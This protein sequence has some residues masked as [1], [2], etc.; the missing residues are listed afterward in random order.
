MLSKT[1]MGIA[2]LSKATNHREHD[3][4]VAIAELLIVHMEVGNAKIKLI[5]H[6]ARLQRSLECA[7]VPNPIS[8]T[9]VNSL[10]KH[11][12]CFIS[13]LEMIMHRKS[14]RHQN[15]GL[16]NEKR[17]PYQKQQGSPEFSAM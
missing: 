7:R 9:V 16:H 3:R 13:W 1:A 2:R 11:G 12:L 15:F 5:N 14:N 8:N 6:S 10:A 17:G 4:D